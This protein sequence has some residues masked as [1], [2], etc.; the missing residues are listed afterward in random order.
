M[1]FAG[2]RRA[3]GTPRGRCDSTASRSAIAAV[4][5]RDAARRARLQER[6]CFVERELEPASATARTRELLQHGLD[7]RARGAVREAKAH[8]VGA[9]GLTHARQQL[10]EHAARS[11]RRRR[12]LLVEARRQNDARRRG[13]TPPST[14]PSVARRSGSGCSRSSASSSRRLIRAA[15]ALRDESA[16]DRGD[17][18]V[19]DA[20][21]T[22]LG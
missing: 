9:I 10:L 4:A 13:E 18:A 17:R 16:V 2:D 7:D 19:G 21:A 5:E 6:R 1:P 8:G 14:L 11:G 3:R 20:E 22:E 12:A 15:T